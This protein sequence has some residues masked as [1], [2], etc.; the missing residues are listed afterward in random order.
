[1]SD[2]NETKHNPSTESPA[3]AQNS[4]PTPTSSPIDHKKSVKTASSPGSTGSVLKIPATF[5]RWFWTPDYR[6]GVTKLFNKL[7]AGLRESDELINF[8]RKRAAFERAYAHQLQTSLDISLDP[9]G[10]GYDDGASFLFAYK[11][12]VSSQSDLAA[13]HSKLALQLDRLV[14]GPFETWSTEHEQR[15]S[16]SIAKVES[17]LAQWEKQSR[18]VTK[19]KE[20]YERKTREADEAEEDSSFSPAAQNPRRVS[21]PSAM[22][23]VEGESTVIDRTGFAPGESYTEIGKKVGEQAIG[24]GRAVSK[25]MRIGGGRVGFR[26]KSLESTLQ[27]RKAKANSIS[28]SN[29]VER[30]EKLLADEN[31]NF[32]RGSI[33]KG[34]LLD[35]VGV[36]KPPFEWSKLFEKAHKTVYKQSVKIPLLGTYPDAHSG[37]DLVIFFKT[38]IPELGGKIDSA[39]EFCRQLS[40][41]LCILRLI[42]E[43]GN[44]FMPTHDAFYVWKPEAFVLHEMSSTSEFDED[45]QVSPKMKK[46]FSWSESTFATSSTKSSFGIISPLPYINSSSNGAE[47]KNVSSGGFAKYF[48][49]AVSQAAKGINE[50]SATVGVAA[51]SISIDQHG[52]SRAE[53]LRRESL[54]AEKVYFS[55]VTRLDE[56][57]LILEQTISEHCSFL[58]KCELDRLRAGKAVI[59]GFNAAVATLI[60]RMREMASHANVL[61]ES[62][63]P[64]GD[65]SALVERYRTGP[66][67]PTPVQFHSCRDHDVRFNFGID[68][69]KWQDAQD[70]SELTNIPGVP[71]VLS[72]LLENLE[73]KYPKIPSHS[74]RRKAWI[75]D[76]P[77][78]AVHNLRMALNNPRKDLIS[79]AQ[80]DALDAPLLAATVKLWLLEL[81]PPAVHYSRYEDVKAIYPQLA[82]METPSEDAKI[83]VLAALL[84]RLPKPNLMVLDAIVSHL[85]NLINSTEVQEDDETYLSKLGLSLSKG[86]IY[87]YYIYQAPLLRPKVET[88]ITL[89]DRFQPLFVIDLIKY[90]DRI[91]PVAIG[92]R[93]KLIEQERKKPQRKHT[94]PVDMR[95]RRSELGIEGSVSDG[96]AQ[97]I[98]QKHRRRISHLEPGAALHSPTEDLKVSKSLTAN[99]EKFSTAPDEVAMDQP[100]TPPMSAET[101]PLKEKDQLQTN[102]GQIEQVDLTEAKLEGHPNIRR[103]PP[104]TSSPIEVLKEP[105]N[106]VSPLDAPFV[107]PVQVDDQ[108]PTDMPFV[109]PTQSNFS[110][111]VTGRGYP[112]TL[113]DDDIPLTAKANLSRLSS[114]G[115]VN[116]SLSRNRGIVN[117]R[118]RSGSKIIR[119]S[120]VASNSNSP[121]PSS[122]GGS[123][124]PQKKGPSFD[125]LR[126]QFESTN[127]KA[128]SNRPDLPV[129]PETSASNR[130]RRAAPAK[131][132]SEVSDS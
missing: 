70:E 94:R 17:V 65:I 108:A 54:N 23:K 112:S 85:R 48:Q 67:R 96:K 91:L 38:N 129:T 29:P 9:D 127:R 98:L 72:R 34:P 61:N 3:N 11:Q 132:L 124:S 78:R 33:S 119:P 2:E 5:D 42:G 19:L 84:S 24:L 30:S 71:L 47:N 131:K 43:I 99:I 90:Y 80:L 110:T 101:S 57:R 125:S 113:D 64:E 37:E 130:Y 60:P 118:S 44:K 89:S 114:G 21:S 75:Y 63:S 117:P 26:A 41:E 46:P 77:L 73:K 16:K 93:N 55:Y 51:P 116:S 31:Q 52:E 13:A 120:S 79:E 76:V 92:L 126:S 36:V 40:Q 97:E 74:E 10:F 83:D 115:G 100:L 107:P 86:M 109:P 59:M 128:A 4:D 62:L 123:T 45:N 69:G 49:S 82:G 8:I 81:D 58:Q 88:S 39:T 106:L 50:L 6:T 28:E 102:E 66:F 111:E 25:S 122:T 103:E 53:R 104:V 20:R 32:P 121:L 15:L 68:L 22:V 87:L 56:A 14:I 18:E 105:E 1:M 27:S 35:I 7:K 12:L 95:V